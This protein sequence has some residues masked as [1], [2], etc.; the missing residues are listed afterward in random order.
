LKKSIEYRTLESSF[1]GSILIVINF[2]QGI[3]FVPFFLDSWGNEKY[4]I[5]ISIFSFITLVKTV[6]LG[7]QN[8]I[9][10]EFNKVFHVNSN[11]A[12]KIIGSSFFV[13]IFLGILESIIFGVTY[14]YFSAN[15]IIG[16][17]RFVITDNNFN[18]SLILFVL[19]WSILGSIGGILVR[20]LLPIGLFNK[21]TQF[22]ILYKLL[23]IGTLLLA[24]NFHFQF[25]TIFFVYTVIN[26]L[27]S[28]LVFIYIKLTL[29][30]F[31]PWWH[32]F[33]LK[34]GLS[35]LA[36]SIVLTFN[37]FIEQFNSSGIV[38]LVTNRIGVST[39]PLFTTIRTST[40]VLLQV[41]SLVTNPLASE[42]IRYNVIGD[43]K[44]ILKI[45]D[46]NCF[47]SSI[48]VNFPFLLIIPFFSRFYFWWTKGQLIL[49][50][51]LYSALMLS[52]CFIN[53]GKSYFT[54]LSSMNALKELMIITFT[55]IV[56]T[57]GLCFLLI[58]DFQLAG[59]GYSI[60]ISE[61]ICSLVLPVFFVSIHFK[62]RISELLKEIQIISIFQ[63][64]IIF[65]LYYHEN[66]NKITNIYLVG[67]ISLIATL[68]MQWKYLDIIIKERIVK[69]ITKIFVK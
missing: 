25:S 15:I 24:I 20:M 68:F 47:L 67:L 37:A 62:L 50:W 52:V 8:Y 42:I 5:W 39:V 23:E 43:K 31:F 16:S 14:F 57:I 34:F 66:Y 21:M 65:L 11:Q 35:N 19:V 3:I 27:Y 51:N 28:I 29:P 22:T 10:N 26:F 9:G 33:D 58:P 56:L 69:L 12:K 32:N 1:W 6:E 13:S 59:V 45:F 55:R 53:F 54:F 30:D 18:F 41:T 46:T 60:V 64:I 44:K 4:G 36:K 40:N 2:V 48:L 49:D 7:H 17:N 61:F 38:L 63:I